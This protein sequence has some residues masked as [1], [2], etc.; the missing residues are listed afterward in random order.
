MGFVDID[1]VDDRLALAKSQI[2]H[3][4]GEPRV[5]KPQEMVSEIERTVNSSY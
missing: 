3:V 1:G 2:I 4:P 5:I